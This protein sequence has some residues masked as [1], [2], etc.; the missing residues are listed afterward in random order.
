M[1]E[2]FGNELYRIFDRE[3]LQRDYPKF[4]EYHRETIQRLSALPKTIAS[5]GIRRIIS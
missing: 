2:T 1:Q 5:M 4:V 3:A